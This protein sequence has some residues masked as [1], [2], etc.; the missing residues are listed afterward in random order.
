MQ[1]I[2]R[3]IS[4]GYD[5][6]IN[7]VY[8]FR[9]GFNIESS[10]GK[11]VLRKL[12]L[13]S[14]RINFI[15][16]AKEYLYNNNLRNIDRFLCTKEGAPFICIDGFNYTVSNAI[17]GR[18]SDFDKR[19]DVIKAAKMLALMHASSRGFN[20]TKNS[21]PRD[22]LGKLPFYFKKRLDEIKRIKKIAQREKRKI[23]YIVLQYIDYFYDLGED[24]VKKL[25]SS[26]YDEIVKKTRKERLFCHH[27][28]T[29]SNIIINDGGTWL[30]NFNYC[31]FELKVYD[32][33]NL[34]RRKMRKCK[35]NVNEASLIVESYSSIEPLSEDEFFVMRIILQFP[36][37]FWRVI[38]KYYN[39]RRTWREKN[40]FS[41]FYD[42]V[43]EIDYH[44]EFLND[45]KL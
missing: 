12:N 24:A 45:F 14:E 4:R 42:V 3:Q 10:S 38:N 27:D 18:E 30:V 2:E 33:A 32:I 5:I 44:K 34:L 29:H 1:E 23:D 9:D 40:Y 22:E 31:C 43:D 7:Y 11:K 15:H 36:Q 19:E 16:E 21:L 26:K 35:W 20:P 28:Y 25:H 6:D 13:S 17:E 39:S 37:K 41:V 8:P